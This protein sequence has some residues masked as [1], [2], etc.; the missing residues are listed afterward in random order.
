MDSFKVYLKELDAGPGMGDLNLS[1]SQKRVLQKV[2]AAGDPQLAVNSLINSKDGMNLMA[3]VK[4]LADQGYL[5]TEPMDLGPHDEPTAITLTDAGDAAIEKQDITNDTSIIDPD[6]QEQGA[7]QEPPS[8]DDMGLG[9]MGGMAPPP[10]GGD[11]GMGGDLGGDVDG[12]EPPEGGDLGEPG[13]PEG[14]LGGEM[15]AEEPMGD[16]ELGPEEEPV[17]D[18]LKGNGVGLELSSFFQ[19][20]NDLSKYIKN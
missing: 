13:E 8:G 18:K 14:E 16:E 17:K 1:R 10:P 7:P 15:G 9:G 20:I 3:A 11:M 5:E 12:E 6:E 4:E 2:S 19:N